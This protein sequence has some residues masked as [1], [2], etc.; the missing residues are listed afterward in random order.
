M[1]PCNIIEKEESFVLFPLREHFG[2][3]ISEFVNMGLMI[4]KKISLLF[5]IISASLV[6]TSFAGRQLHNT[7]AEEV[8]AS[9]EQLHSKVASSVHERLLRANTKDYG[10]Y[11]PSPTLGKPPFKLIPN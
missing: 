3:R 1:F 6:S 7:L 5:L 2:K 10:T 11:D 8:D 9:H 4:L